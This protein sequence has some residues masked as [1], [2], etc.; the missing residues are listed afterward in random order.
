LT[1]AAKDGGKRLDVKVKR[2]SVEP[3][4]LKIEKGVT[5]FDFGRES[6]T[7]ITDQVIQLDLSE[8]EE[9]S[10]VVQQT[11]NVQITSGAITWTKLPKK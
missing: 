3:M 2:V 10:F 1:F 4:V 11:G 5:T 9:G 7:I 6:V 8:R